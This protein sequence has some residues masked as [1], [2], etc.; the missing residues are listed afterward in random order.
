M[1]TNPKQHTVLTIGTFDGVHIGH[2]KIIKR[3][4]EVANI[5]GLQPSL[6]TFFPHPRM[7]LQK[8]ANIKLINTISEKEQL[9]KHFGITNLVV[10]KFTKEFSRLTALDYVENLLVNQLKSKY[11]I[12]GYDHHFGRNRNAN[13]NNL[14]QFGEDFNFEVEE[15]SM[16][17]INDVAISSTKIRTALN[18]GDIKTANTYLGYN[19]MLTGTIVKGKGLGKT[20]QYPTANLHIEETYKL[21]PKQGVYVV[22]ALIDDTIQYGMMNIG[23]NPTVNGQSQT[24]ETHFFNF[25][26]SLYDKNISIQL[27]ERL[28]DE[29]KFDG[30]KQLTTQ[31]DQDKTQALQYIQD[32][33]K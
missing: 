27:L 2:Q 16:Q 20:I 14:K 1:K 33:A 10:K 15:I 22:K 11:I 23:N 31:L 28:R 13:I 29:Q 19:F 3:L 21:I 4:V 6:L 18:E 32:Y 17:D 30:L 24:I 5:K 25:N 12:I 26:N 8:D 7:V 9:L